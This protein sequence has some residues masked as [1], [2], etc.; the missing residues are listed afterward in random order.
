MRKLIKRYQTGGGVNGTSTKA[1]QSTSITANTNNSGAAS[2]LGNGVLGASGWSSGEKIVNDSKAILD[3][4]TSNFNPLST[5]GGEGLLGKLGGLGQ[6]ALG[7][8][9]GLGGAFSLGENLMGSILGRP[10][11]NSGAFNTVN[12]VLNL[13]KNI[14]GIGGVAASGLSFVLNG[15]N[16]LGARNLDKVNND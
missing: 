12:S 9:G 14:P 2:L 11:I 15:I 1:G 16:S 13:A 7:A 10:D 6:K 3:K 5:S 8:V 4:F